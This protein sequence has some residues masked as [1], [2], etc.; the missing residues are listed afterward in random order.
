LSNIIKSSQQ[1]QDSIRNLS[2][3]YKLNIKPKT[4]THQNIANH[5]QAQKQEL[6]DD[7]ISK[8][9]E[10]AKRIVDQ[11][12]SYG[13]YYMKTTTDRANEEY[14]LASQKVQDEN[15]TNIE[16][17]G[18]DA[19]LEKGYQEGIRQAEEETQ[20]LVTFL[21]GVIEG[22]DEGKLAL[23]KKYEEDLKE[24]A[25]EIAK[26]I[27]KKELEVSPETLRNIIESAA[28]MSKNQGAMR[29]SVSPKSYSL[30]TGEGSEL[31]RRLNGISDDVK[32]ISDSSLKD[33]D[34]YIETP[35]GF[36]D[37][38]VDTQL[39]NIE[40]AIKHDTKRI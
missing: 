21:E 22:V 14:Q 29:I 36:I 34:C 28:L 2:D 3:S 33:T 18:Y 12:Q 40:L 19:G 8:A 7:I 1:S 11:A 5:T 9:Q 16:Q 13:I 24:L 32:F 31:E 23:V 27:V 6:A 4:P 17:K 26:T 15:M 20:R 30:L 39:N 25:F 10:Q 37:A 38:S 35:I